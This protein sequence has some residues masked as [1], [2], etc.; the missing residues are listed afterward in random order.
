MYGF[1]SRGSYVEVI[2]GRYVGRRGTVVDVDAVQSGQFR[3]YPV[4][5]LEPKGRAPA[6]RHRFVSGALRVI[7][8]D[9]PD[10]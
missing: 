2:S 7:E 3:L 10:A 6:R 9:D 8:R 5:Y 1:P 4:V